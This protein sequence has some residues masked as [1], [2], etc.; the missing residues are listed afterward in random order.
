M[1]LVVFSPE[2]VVGS[3]SDGISQPVGGGNEQQHRNPDDHKETE[4]AE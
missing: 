1:H 4:Q 3:F 2:Q